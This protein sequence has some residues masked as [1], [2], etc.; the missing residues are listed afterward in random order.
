MGPPAALAAGHCGRAARHFGRVQARGRDDHLPEA[1]RSGRDGHDDP[2]SFGRRE[3]LRTYVFCQQDEPF[4]WAP[5]MY[6]SLPARRATSAFSGGFYVPQHHR[7]DGGLGEGLEAARSMEPDLL[8]SF[9]GTA[10]N[11]PVRKRLLELHDTRAIVKDTADWSAR[12]R[13][14]WKTRYCEESRQAFDLYAETLGRSTFIV[15]P[16]GRGPASIRLFEAMQAGRAPVIVSDEWLPPP[17]VDWDACS[18]RVAEDATADLP[19]I[20]RE[21][22]DEAAEL[23]R[24]VPAVV[25]GVLLARAAARN[26]DQSVCA[27][28]RNL[29]EA[30][31]R[32]FPRCV[33]S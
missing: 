23:G 12:I 26:P 13:W 8:W 33:E 5:G 31:R 10:S 28:R 14:A 29:T 6:A 16:R 11:H 4:A 9:M 20:L 18:V 17:F 27:N 2:R 19:A 22:E 3:L 24:R 25:G 7:E 32:I 1:C 15:C 30:T 21:R